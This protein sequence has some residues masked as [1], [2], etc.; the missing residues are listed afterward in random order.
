MP[1]SV[2]VDDK[3]VTLGPTGECGAGRDP[4]AGLLRDNR[5][6]ERIRKNV[7]P[8]DDRSVV[9][10]ECNVH[11]LQT[12]ARLTE[13]FGAALAPY[14]L[15]LAKY[16]LLVVLRNSPAH[17]L[18]MNEIGE[19]M[20]VSCANITKLVDGLE[21]EGF[22]RR[23]DLPCDRRVVLTEITE[24]GLDLLK[25]VMPAQYANLRKL[26][27]TLS[28]DDCLTLTHLLLKLKYGILACADGGAP[29]ERGANCE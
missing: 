8:G 11:L 28:D 27:S 4:G 5:L 6:V 24:S 20:S 29:V 3:V 16:N 9:V 21:R 10:A 7:G 18:R 13:A 25:N 26:T 15:T 19:Q 22:V 1:K 14:G 17:R 2:G 23:A 12:H